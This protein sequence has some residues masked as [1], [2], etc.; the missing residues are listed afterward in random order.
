[1][2][3]RRKWSAC[4][5]YTDR[6]S[7]LHVINV[8]KMHAKL[9]ALRHAYKINEM[10]GHLAGL[11]VFFDSSLGLSDGGRYHLTRWQSQHQTSRSSIHQLLLMSAVS[12]PYHTLQTGLTMVPLCSSTPYPIA[13]DV[14]AHSHR[15]DLVDIWTPDKHLLRTFH[16]RVR[17]AL[18]SLVQ[19]SH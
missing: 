6:V 2:G 18:D 14:C 7:R 4:V 10:L 9:P 5:C 19:L 12:L 17:R 11:I 8:E 1:M 3:P 13:T 16:Q 15:Y